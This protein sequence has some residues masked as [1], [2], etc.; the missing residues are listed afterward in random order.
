M[1]SILGLVLFDNSMSYIRLQNSKENPEG[2]KKKLSSILIVII[3]LSGL[4][5]LLFPTLSDFLNNVS[6][7]KDI[8][9][10]ADSVA[11][12][13]SGSSP[14]TDSDTSSSAQESM[15]GRQERG[16]AM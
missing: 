4:S 2:M 3:L 13:H 1:D 16:S 6:R 8:N 10:Y 15:S 5:L 9:T 11:A 7:A 12:E 14:G